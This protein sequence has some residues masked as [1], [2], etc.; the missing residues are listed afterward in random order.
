MKTNWDSIQTLRETLQ[1]RWDRGFF[2]K[3]WF[4]ENSLFPYS[5]SIQGPATRDWAEQFVA[6]QAWVQTYTESQKNL[7]FAL[8]WKEVNHRTLGSNRIPYHAT[9]RD[10]A[11]LA[12]FVYRTTELKRFQANAQALQ[13]LLP[14]L[15]PWLETHPREALME[16]APWR[17]CLRLLQWMR[18]HPQ[19]QIYLRQIPLPG[20]D[21]KFI[22][23]HQKLLSIW[24]TELGSTGGKNEK[25]SPFGKSSRFAQRFGFF[26]KPELVRIRFLDSRHTL[27][28][29]S[30]LTL[31]VDELARWTPP[32]QTWIVVEND[33]TALSLPDLPNTAVLFGRGYGFEPL[34]VL[35][36]LQQVRLFYWGDL[37]THG[38]A[39]LSQFRALFPQTQSLLM[40][41]ATLLEH[42]EQW[43]QEEKPT[44]ARLEHLQPEESSLYADLVNNRLGEHVRLEQERIAFDWIQK[45]LQPQARSWEG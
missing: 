25:A 42:Q 16:E 8:E 34:C 4:P 32:L 20:I 3:G 41:R 35:S 30:D 21:T 5:L 17:Q 19:P 36:W 45:T 23:G 6:I 37:D 28:G 31:R 39:I 26:A 33:I 9:F 2:W 7:G 43:V 1:R 13:S 11:Q 38:F 15:G 24:L 12:A 27:Q 44:G 18:A 14:D 29:F 10:L 40:D 22:Q